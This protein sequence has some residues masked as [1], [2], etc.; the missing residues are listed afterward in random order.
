[1]TRRMRK[2]TKCTGTCS[3]AQKPSQENQP[4]I[5]FIILSHGQPGARTSHVSRTQ[6]YNESHQ[7]KQVEDFPDTDP[8]LLV[9]KVTVRFF[10]V[11]L[12]K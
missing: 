4:A 7:T 3:I 10:L 11:G 8:D 5:R 2:T 12:L 1:M 9:Q 6:S